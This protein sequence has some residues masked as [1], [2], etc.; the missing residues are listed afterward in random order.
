MVYPGGVTPIPEVCI[1]V[2]TSGSMSSEDIQ[3]LLPEAQECL[4]SSAGSMGR[5][6]V[7]DMKVHSLKVVTDVRKIQIVGRSGTD[8]RVGFEAISKLRPRPDI[9]VVFTDGGTYWPEN[10]L[11]G[12]RTI[13]ALCGRWKE[14]PDSVPSWCKVIDIPNNN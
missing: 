5:V 1:L 13:V 3:R 12:T 11:R 2:D 7:C 6:C 4:R 14:S 10:A 9:L 8:L